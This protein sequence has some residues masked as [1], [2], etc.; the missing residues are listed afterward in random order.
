MD[1]SGEEHHVGNW[2]WAQN[3]IWN[4]TDGWR[5]STMKS[6]SKKLIMIMFTL[7]Y[8]HLGIRTF[9]TLKISLLYQ[10]REQIVFHSIRHVSVYGRIQQ[11]L[12][13]RPPI[14][15]VAICLNLWW[16][17]LTISCGD[18]VKKKLVYW[19]PCTCSVAA[20]LVGKVWDLNL[21]R[22]AKTAAQWQGLP[23]R[24][25]LLLHVWKKRLRSGVFIWL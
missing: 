24:A 2:A 13:R 10:P 16:D 14:F 1:V 12:E 18:T 3:L 25:L 9:V 15:L 23:I 7:L 5:D 8:N 19:Q 4:W 22:I 6:I 11:W 21:V 17:E 20:L